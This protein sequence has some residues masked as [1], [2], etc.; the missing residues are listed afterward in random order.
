MLSRILLVFAGLVLLGLAVSALFTVEATE[1]IYVTR[2]GAHAATYDGATEAGL[3][4]K[5]PW[6]VDS[7]QRL[8]RRLHI[9]DLAGAELLTHDPEG[10]TIDKTLTISAYVCWRIADNV[11]V[12]TF[13]RTV[14][15]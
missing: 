6:P 10:Q 2:F 7:V 12:D 4:I 3:K 5:W 1:Y 9:F 15:T 13:L 8:D 11:G 14:A